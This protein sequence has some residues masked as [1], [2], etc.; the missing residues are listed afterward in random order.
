MNMLDIHRHEQCGKWMKRHNRKMPS[1][2]DPDVVNLQRHYLVSYGAARILKALS[3]GIVVDF[4][5]LAYLFGHG[6]DGLMVS[7]EFCVIR[8]RIP[9]FWPRVIKNCGYV[10]DDEGLIQELRRA[11]EA[12]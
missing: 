7:T 9:H 3:Y 10:I 6:V 1:K 8:R 12:A 2:P 11:M 5:L 4:D